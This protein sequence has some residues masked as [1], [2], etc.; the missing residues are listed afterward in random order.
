MRLA[1]RGVKGLDDVC[2]FAVIAWRVQLRALAGVCLQA[3]VADSTV[4]TSEGVHHT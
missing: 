4:G 3:R 1:L 2:V